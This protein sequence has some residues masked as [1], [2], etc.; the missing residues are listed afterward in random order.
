MIWVGNNNSSD[1]E[2]DE[3]EEKEE[4]SD[5]IKEEPLWNPGK[6]SQL[7]ISFDFIKFYSTIF[8]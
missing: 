7:D 8:Y 6:I 1:N 2:E 4:N 5:E 3:K